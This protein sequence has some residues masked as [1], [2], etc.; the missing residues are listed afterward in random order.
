MLDRIVV[1]AKKTPLEELLVR[2]SFSQAAFFLAQRGTSIEEYQAAHKQYQESLTTVIASLP[3]SVPH[4]VINREMIAGFL[5]R[6]N[7]LLIVIGPD[8]LCVNVAKYISDQ[9]ILAVNPD[10]K[11]IDGVLM[12][13]KPSEIKTM[14]AEAQQNGLLTESVTLAKVTTNDGQSLYAVNDFLIGRRDQVSARYTIEWRGKKERQSSSGILV[15][16]GVG[17]TG[18]LASVMGGESAGL[19]WDSQELVFAVREPFPSKYTGAS[20]I[21]DHIKRGESLRVISEMPEGGFIFSDGVPEDAIEFNS[22]TIA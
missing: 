21:F 6:E 19:R 5:F 22:G 16:T 9:P 17:S 15:S 3:K 11:R 12:R 18:W 8:G 2:Q 4:A 7:D 1:V 10:R 14:I 13:I 20:I